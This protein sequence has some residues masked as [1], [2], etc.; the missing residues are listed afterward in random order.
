M[1]DRDKQPSGLEEDQK[2]FVRETWESF[3]HGFP[4]EESCWHF[5]INRMRELDLLRCHYCNC[6]DIAIDQELRTYRCLSCRGRS[7]LTSG[8]IF[9]RVRKLRAWL[10]AI[11]L[12]EH[13]AILSSNWFST[14]AGIA[15]SSSLKI[16]HSIFQVLDSTTS[17][18]T[19]DMISL[20]SLLFQPIFT[21][22]SLMTP[23]SGHP[24]DEEKSER[25][26]NR[27]QS[28]TTAAFQDT[29]QC[30]EDEDEGEGEAS[31]TPEEQ[32]RL[33]ALADSNSSQSILE[34]ALTNDEVMVMELLKSAPM[35][36]DELLENT[37][38]DFPSLNFII[39]NLEM[40]GHVISI[41]GGKIKRLETEEN[42]NRLNPLSIPKDLS[43]ELRK[44]NVEEALA[45]SLDANLLRLLSTARLNFIMLIKTYFQG[46][47]RKYL[48][49]YLA[50]R[51]YL[52]QVAQTA[53][54]KAPWSGKQG[55]STILDLC[56]LSRTKP[57][58]NTRDFV[59]DLLTKFHLPADS[60]Q[61][62]GTA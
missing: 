13:G 53:E 19:A 21:K 37:G 33:G 28:K 14:L 1:T 8:T 30:S 36:F 15:Q 61:K 11:W 43:E 41:P 10:A 23:R 58:L 55:Q 50:L 57:I 56:L 35:N 12:F 59:T 16:F 31:F 20:P 26:E 6:C 47:S 24:A 48:A 49:L 32:T 17:T 29:P 42:T 9:H 7:W 45:G 3:S 54:T 22:R 18:A 44:E 46:I 62:T 51:N 27:K 25:E 52:N 38:L 4:T 34:Q 39:I 2:Q 5:L 60:I 40:A